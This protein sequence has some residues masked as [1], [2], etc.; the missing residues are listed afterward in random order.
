MVQ[1]LRGS[2]Q[3]FY[4]DNGYLLLEGAL[5]EK[6]LTQLRTA[7]GD[8]MAANGHFAAPTRRVGLHAS[9]TRDKPAYE[10]IWNPDLDS[11][12]VWNFLSKSELLDIIEGLIGP[13]IRFHHSSLLFKRPGIT[14]YDWHQ[15]VAYLP[16][17]NAS[18]MLVCIYLEECGPQDA[19]N[20]VIPGSHKGPMFSHCDEKGSFTG[21]IAEHDLRMVDTASKVELMGPAGTIEIFNTRT[22]HL[23]DFGSQR[24]GGPCLHVTYTAADAAP[25]IGFGRASDRYGTIVR[26][27]PA[28][29]A[30][31]DPEGCP[32]PRSYAEIDRRFSLL[33]TP[34][35]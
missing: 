3:Q 31:H 8:V 14:S 24:D 12:T 20:V 34:A 33:G 5:S 30:R 10:W 26:G 22:I 16:H 7:I 29:F 18:P 2:D 23:D 27:Q 28:K 17:T 21:R 25:Y 13:D 1:V 19:R 15:D 6:W 11:D 4:A 35:G 9:H 32:I